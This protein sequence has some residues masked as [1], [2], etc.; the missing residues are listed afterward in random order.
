MVI[1]AALTPL[2]ATTTTVAGSKK[3]ANHIDGPT[4]GADGKKR[5]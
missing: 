4:K 1:P 3:E 5:D 2:T